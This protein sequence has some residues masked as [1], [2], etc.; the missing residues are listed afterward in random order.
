MITK[1]RYHCTMDKY[2]ESFGSSGSVHI[3]Q[4]S[5]LKAPALEWLIQLYTSMYGGQ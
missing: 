3:R 2:S 5:A 1:N 4:V